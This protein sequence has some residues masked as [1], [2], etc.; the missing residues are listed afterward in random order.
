MEQRLV[1]FFFGP[2][3]IPF[4]WLYDR[5]DSIA[6]VP[7]TSTAVNVVTVGWVNYNYGL[8]KI[9]LFQI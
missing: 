4:E 2:Y 6:T 5:V 8:V 7:A 9:V 3:D 1:L